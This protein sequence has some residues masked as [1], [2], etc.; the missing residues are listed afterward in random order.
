[1][2]RKL[3]NVLEYTATYRNSTYQ[4]RASVLNGL[5]TLDTRLEATDCILQVRHCAGTLTLSDNLC[6]PFYNS[7]LPK[8]SENPH[9]SII[10]NLCA[11]AASIVGYQYPGT[12]DGSGIVYGNALRLCDAILAFLDVLHDDVIV[13]LESQLRRGH[14]GFCHVIPKVAT[15]LRDYNAAVKASNERVKKP[16]ETVLEYVKADGELCRGI[17]DLQITETST[18][19]ED[20]RTVESAVSLVEECKEVARVFSRSLTAATNA[21]NDLNPKLKRKF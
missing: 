14:K 11:S 9:K 3:L 21:I 10:H 6:K 12:Y 20:E 19:A 5:T 7:T 18:P 8:D 13:P 16:I 2:L 4:K 1:M 15:G 17:N